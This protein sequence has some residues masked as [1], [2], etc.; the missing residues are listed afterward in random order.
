MEPVIGTG[1]IFL[2]A[3]T[4]HG[5]GA[6][7]GVKRKKHTGSGLQ[8]AQILSG[9]ESRVFRI[10]R[11][12][13]VNENPDGDTKLKLGEA[14]EMRNFRIT[15]DG[16]LQIRPGTKTVLRFDGPVRGMWHGLV[17]DMEVTVCA[18]EG[19]LWRMDPELSMKTRI[20]TL[21]DAP[22]EFFGFSKRLYILTGHEYMVWDG[23]SDAAPVTGYRPLVSVSTPPA[24]GGQLLESVNKL[25]GLRRARFSPDGT[26]AVF[27]L[28]EKNIASVD[29]VT[30]LMTGQPIPYTENLAEGTVTLAAAPEKGINSVEIGWTFPEN[31]RRLVEGMRF[32]ELYSG[33]TD[34][35]VFLYGDG[36]NRAIYSGLDYDGRPSAEYFPDPCVLHAGEE[37]TPITGMIRH[38]SMLLIF[39]S[40]AAYA[41]SYDTVTLDDG[42]ASAALYIKPINRDIG[43][44]AR[45]QTRL[46]TNNPFTLHGAS[47]FEWRP[48]SGQLSIDERNARHI[49][50]RVGGSLG[51]LDLKNCVT[52]DDAENQEYYVCQGERALV[53]NYDEDV[54]YIYTNFP[55][56]CFVSRGR[57]LYFGTPDG[58]I[59]HVS[60]SH[61]SD[62]GAPIDGYWASGSMDFGRDFQRKCSSAIYVTIKPE[63]G[64]RLNVT[65]RSNRRSAHL[66]HP[67]S[68][69][70]AAFGRSD[71]RHWSFSTNRQP[72]VRRIK[73]KVKNAAYYQLVFSSNSTACTATVL[74]CDIAV[75]YTGNVK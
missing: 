55:A 71:F 60:R 68:S 75:R 64:A 6:G 41:A 25:C 13:G 73:L 37:N 35:R 17:D 54:W 3:D 53:Y 50:G 30:D 36:S 59:R 57:E 23:V 27:R 2:S 67:L 8:V 45:G 15:R 26:A 24:G 66:A 38:F 69:N 52:Y 34:A 58:D 29:F 10:Q 32:S 22:T 42:L 63:A 72:Q 16:N 21:T 20:G 33:L 48:G 49:S 19:A 65:A 46:I 51:G 9:M 61:R 18:A 70:L 47:V 40:T 14:S 62:D 11:W 1:S 12:F 44:A 74:T 28:P 7:R 39:K 4:K 5:G 31:G 56:A 43:N